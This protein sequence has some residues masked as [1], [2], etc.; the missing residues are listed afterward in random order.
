MNSIVEFS[1]LYTALCTINSAICYW[2]RLACYSLVQSKTRDVRSKFENENENATEKRK[3]QILK[4]KRKWETNANSQTQTR[5]ERSNPR[6]RWSGQRLVD[7]ELAFNNN[8]HYGPLPSGLI[9]D[10]FARSWWRLRSKTKKWN[11]ATSVYRCLTFWQD[12]GSWLCIHTPKLTFRR[13]NKRKSSVL[14]A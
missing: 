12:L 2:V 1:S 6:Y 14:Y 11:L 4:R 8:Y 3:I 10:N 5:D 9:I 7:D 13:K